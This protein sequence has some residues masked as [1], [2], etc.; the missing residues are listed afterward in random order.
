M[1]ISGLICEVHMRTDANNL[2]TTASTTHLPD[3]KETIHMIQMLRKEACSGGIE[4]LSHVKSEGCLSDC[5]TKHSAKPDN[6]IKAS[7]T[8]VLPNVDSHPLFRTLLQH[9]AFLGEWAY[10]N[11]DLPVEQ[12]FLL[13]EEI[14]ST[15]NNPVKDFWTTRGNNLVRMHVLPRSC[16]IV[17]RQQDCPV[18]I[19]CLCFSRITDMVTETGDKARLEDTWIEQC[20]NRPV[21]SCWTGET[22]F[23]LRDKR[24]QA[25]VLAQE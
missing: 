8:G 17:P 12:S 14:H 2:V 6:L 18:P 20:S 21:H 11:L 23:L 22:V 4:D 24:L 1:D 3:Q 25:D 19:S 16:L 10:K 9:R 7:E 15:R 13:L 5:L